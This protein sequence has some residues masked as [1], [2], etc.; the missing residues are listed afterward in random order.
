MLRSP[1]L[2]R[3]PTLLMLEDISIPLDISS[4]VNVLT[5][6]VRLY[7]VILLPAWQSEVLDGERFETWQAT[8]L[9]SIGLC[10]VSS[11]LP[12]CWTVLVIV[13]GPQLLMCLVRTV[14][15][16][17]LVLMWVRTLQFTALLWARL[18]TLQKPPKK[19]NRTGG[20]LLLVLGYSRWNRLTVENTTVLYIGL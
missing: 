19:P 18:F 6:L 5:E 8:A 1:L 7:R 14:L 15:G 13:S 3:V 2:I 10:L 11:S 4:L 20:P 12:P 16:P 17:M 9:S